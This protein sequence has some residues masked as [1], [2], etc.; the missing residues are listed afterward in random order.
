M[1]NKF[2]V[3]SAVAKVLFYSGIIKLFR[4]VLSSGNPII[5]MYHQVNMPEFEQH[6]GY[7]KK[8]FNV[9][10][11]RELVERLKNKHGFERGTVV[12]TFDDGYLNNYEHAYPILK[13]LVLPATIFVTTGLIGTKKL[14]WWDGIMCAIKKSGEDYYCFRFKNRIIHLDLSTEKSKI[15]SVAVLHKVLSKYGFKE[16]EEAMKKIYSELYDCTKEK[17][18]GAYKF[19]SWKEARELSDNGIE[20]GSH[21]VTHPFLTNISANEMVRELK[22]SKKEIEK[23][24][25]KKVFSFCYPSGDFGEQAKLYVQG[26]GY[27]CACSIVRGNVNRYSDIYSLE[28]IGINIKDDL[29]IFALKTS[30]LWNFIMSRA[31]Y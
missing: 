31:G 1:K 21:T 5:L 4:K 22:G 2:A 13:K 16:R 26:I 7:L 27:G 15:E 25:E 14:A 29:P 9:I 19:M 30:G 6:M 24:I 10:G 3:K 28:R 17:D 23:K 8:N 18:I 11:L 12:I 20:I